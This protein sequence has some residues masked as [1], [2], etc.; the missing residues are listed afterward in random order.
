M[1]H[2]NYFHSDLNSRMSMASEPKRNA[3]AENHTLWKLVLVLALAY[4]V[5]SDRL[6]IV[7]N[8][9]GGASESGWSSRPVA[10]QSRA[11]ASLLPADAA[12]APAA[13]P[14]A[15]QP[16]QAFSVQ[17]PDG[18]HN[19][20]TLAMDPEFAARNQLELEEVR[21]C[22]NKCAAYIEQYAQLAIA[23]QQKF[24]IPAS[25]T[26]AQGLLES[27]AG[28]SK[29]ARNTNNHF[30]IKCFSRKCKRGHCKNFT[31]DSHKDFFVQYPNVWS[32]YRAH[33]KFLKNA[34]RY[35][36]LFRLEPADYQG[37]AR[38][39]QKAGYATDRKYGDKL[40]AIIENLNL[41]RYDRAEMDE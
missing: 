8:P 23:E 29:L 24:G 32:S 10:N 35:A 9:N 34:S 13:K 7:F 25:I 2:S 1:E 30:G 40:I 37:W 39:L 19:N 14:R 4:L 20:V 36:K 5:W 3:N 27:N 15:P 33:S 26:L 38:G 31:D 17:L 12:P 16:R 28:E 18:P 6:T 41:D 21:V 11:Q 22:R